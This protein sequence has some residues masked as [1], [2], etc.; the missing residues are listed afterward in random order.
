MEWW[1]SL[2]GYYSLLPEAPAMAH[3]M[4]LFGMPDAIGAVPAYLAATSPTDF[5]VY[6]GGGEY[7]P[8]EG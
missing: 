5:S 2:G 4:A 8:Q 3:D 7:A 1:E 6:P